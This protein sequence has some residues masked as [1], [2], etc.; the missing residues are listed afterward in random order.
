MP[1]F[2][3]ALMLLLQRVDEALRAER[4]RPRPNTFLLALLRLRQRRL[5]AR[6]NRSLGAA[7]LAGR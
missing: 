6:L 3:F 4:R 5:S 2:T 1:S 7:M